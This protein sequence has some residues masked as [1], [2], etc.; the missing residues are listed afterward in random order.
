MTK[1]TL[2]IEFPLTLIFPVGAQIPTV[3][4]TFPSREAVQFVPE[5]QGQWERLPDGRIRATFNSRA[6]M[7]LCMMLV[8][9]DHHACEVCSIDQQQACYHNGGQPAKSKPERK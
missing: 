2:V 3:A 5:G 6:E 8:A 4:A 9:C 1:V 7:R